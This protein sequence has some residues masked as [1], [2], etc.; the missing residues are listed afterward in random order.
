MEW[1][2][3]KTTTDKLQATLN[4]ASECGREIEKIQF[5]GGRDWV[6]VSLR[7]LPVEREFANAPST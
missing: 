1:A 5:V 6:V 3:D 2:V 7:E 4:Y